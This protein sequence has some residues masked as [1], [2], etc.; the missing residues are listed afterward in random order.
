[1]SEP[2][3][4][5]VI[6]HTAV[7]ADGRTDGFIPDIGRFYRIAVRWRE[8]ATLVGSGTLLASAEAACDDA[9]E[10][11]A[12]EPH[13]C[14]TRP[15]LVVAD[16]RGRVKCYSALRNAGYWRDAV[17]LCTSSTP[18]DHIKYLKSKRVEMV[19]AGEEQVDLGV[20][21]AE[22]RDRFGVA[23]VRVDSGGTL[24]GSLLRARLVDEVSVLIHPTLVGGLSPRSFFRA[25]DVT[26]PSQ[27]IPMQ[28]VHA[29][30]LDDGLVW[31]R[32][33]VKRN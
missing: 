1:M 15:L 14:E 3:L 16:S 21:L 23:T 32:Y 8:D 20:A 7:S 27:V 5:R 31:L 18:H 9:A 10:S 25:P 29:E 26:D 19:F 28:L 17:A 13:P 33:E 6:V 2:S 30:P 4:P 11:P 12:P 24:S 22:L